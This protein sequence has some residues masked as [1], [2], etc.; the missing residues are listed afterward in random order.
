MQKQIILQNQKA[1]DI[2][3]CLTALDIKNYQV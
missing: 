3:T 2:K 1:H